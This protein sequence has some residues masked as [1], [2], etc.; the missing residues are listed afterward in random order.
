LQHMNKF[1]CYNFSRVLL[2][3]NNM[4]VTESSTRSPVKSPARSPVKSPARSVF[5]IA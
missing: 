4:F 5:A 2:Q 1:F 3:L